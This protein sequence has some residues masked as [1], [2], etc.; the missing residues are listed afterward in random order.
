MKK[1]I[2]ISTFAVYVFCCV[3]FAAAQSTITF[4]DVPLA[5]NSYYNGS[6]YAGGFSSGNLF[7]TNSYTDYGYGYTSWENWAVSNK[8]D[9]TT[10]GYGNQY[11]AITGGGGNNSA[12]YAV[13][14]PTFASGA[15]TISLYK[16]TTVGGFYVTNTT[17]DY[18]SMLNGDQYAKQFGGDYGIDPDYF[19][20]IVTGYDLSGVALGS[21]DVYL[22]DYRSSDSAEDYILNQWKW[23][24]LT[25]LGTN[26]ASV[27]FKFKSS[28]VGAYGINTPTYF[29]MDNLTIGSTN[30]PAT[31]KLFTGSANSRFWSGANVWN[32]GSF[33]SG[34]GLLFNSASA[35][36]SVNDL[37]AETRVGT[38]TFGAQAA[39]TTISG[40]SVKLA[41]DLGNYSLETQTVNLAMN[42]VD[43]NKTFYARGNL[44]IDQAIG[45][46]GGSYG[47]TKTGSGSF[48]LNAACSY[49]GGTEIREGK[50]ILSAEGDLAAASTVAV[51]RGATFGVAAGEH[52]IATIS[53]EGTTA[54]EGDAVL[55]VGTLVQD[56]LIL[57]GSG[58]STAQT[59]TAVPEPSAL[60]LLAALGIVTF[61]IRRRS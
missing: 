49:S 15:S 46:E 38:I 10:E 22:A 8:T 33:Q 13:S 60:A 59:L 6:D 26:V 28:D 50:L 9:T 40:S 43:G 44:V 5:A 45:E 30:N 25:S 55:V 19:K 37:T 1:S 29:A 35:T 24:D 21:L 42:L 53:G 7:F 57:G 14:F 32:R 39:A 16:P 61:A 20:V 12:N 27:T 23:V 47:V 11:S 41:G 18:L 54:V 3:G 51:D 2:L 36:A 34:D 56:T 17:Y 52:E 58:A 31:E 48:V 4:D